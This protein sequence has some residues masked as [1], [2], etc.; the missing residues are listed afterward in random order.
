METM[1][2]QLIALDPYTPWSIVCDIVDV[3]DYKAALNVLSCRAL[4]F[5]M[6][7]M[8]SSAYEYPLQIGKKMADIVENACYRPND[9]LDIDN[10]IIYFNEMMFNLEMEIVGGYS[11]IKLKALHKGKKRYTIQCDRMNKQIMRQKN[12]PIDIE[13][14]VKSFL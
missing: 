8:F 3:L 9:R 12:M 4:N 6:M 13:E 10:Q 11:D 2:L 1:R 14:L 7:N 5:G